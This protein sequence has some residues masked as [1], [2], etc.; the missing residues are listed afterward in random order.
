MASLSNF[1]PATSRVATMLGLNVVLIA[2]LYLIPFGI[3]LVLHDRHTLARTHPVTSYGLAALL[4][5]LLIPIALL[6]GGAAN[7]IVAA[8]H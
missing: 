4:L 8:M 2:F 5:I 6:F 1:A 7:V 3:V